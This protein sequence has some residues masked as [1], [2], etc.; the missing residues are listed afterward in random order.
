MCP[1]R[2]PVDAHWT[3]NWGCDRLAMMA[4]MTSDKGTARMEMS[5][6]NG[7]MV[8]IMIEHAHDGQERRDELR[9]ALL[10]R[11]AMLSMSLVTRLSRSP[12]V[13]CRTS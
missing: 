5:A 9:Q 12:R 11:G 4:V 6:S 7:L 13:G 3:T 8:S 2:V 1:L 10:E